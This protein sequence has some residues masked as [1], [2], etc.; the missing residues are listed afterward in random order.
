[1]CMTRE[2]FA[3]KTDFQRCT[4]GEPLLFHSSTSSVKSSINKERVPCAGCGG[5]QHIWSLIEILCRNDRGGR[6]LFVLFT[7][8]NSRNSC[9]KQEGL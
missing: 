5:T 6:S 8:K 9:F 7:T 2:Y 3:E 4:R 1:M